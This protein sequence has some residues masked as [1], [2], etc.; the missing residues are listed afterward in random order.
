MEWT[1]DPTVG[2]WLGERLD[3]TTGS[4]HRAVPRGFPAY[5]RIFHRA[6]TWSLPGRSVPEPR[7]WE[8]MPDAERE[9]LQ[10]EFVDAEVT[11]AETAAAFGTTLHPLAQWHRIVRTPI[12]GD[13]RTRI[14]PDGREFNAP[15]EGELDPAQ[16][17]ALAGMLAAHTSTPDAG[18]AALWE[19]WGNLVGHFGTPSSR[20]LFATDAPADPHH[21]AMLDRSTHDPFNN[22]FRKPT[23][24]D[25][26]LSR[27]ISEGPRLDLPDRA[28]VAFSAA[29]RTFADP[30]WVRSAPWRDPTAEETGSAPAAQAPNL[31]WPED[32]A[33]VM[34]TEIEADSTIVAGSAALVGALCGDGILEALPVPENAYLTW[35]ADGV[36]R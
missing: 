13:W 19:G 12:D 10:R 26:I 11:W 2:A 32:R 6:S 31:L 33:W 23:W 22:V 7:E 20:P 5:A 18:V 4:M 9:R 27:E 8:R 30:G 36:N 28:Y 35:D 29:P 24:Q 1:A 34:V 15:V 17:T 16:L 25:G 3:P 21:R 14:A